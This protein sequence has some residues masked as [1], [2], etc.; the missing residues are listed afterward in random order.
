M[1]DKETIGGP[2]HKTSRLLVEP[3]VENL[4]FLLLLHQRAFEVF[5]QTDMVALG[6]AAVTPR[7]EKRTPSCLKIDHVSGT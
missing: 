6:L 3:Q 2:H 5:M 4:P 1:E 7:R